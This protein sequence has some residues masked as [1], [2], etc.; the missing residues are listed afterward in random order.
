METVGA[1][2]YY[3]FDALG[4]VTNL[5]DENG[6]TSATYRYDVYGDF[7]LTGTSQGNPYTFIGRRYD[8]EIG[9]YYY[10]GRY[11]SPIIGRFLQTDSI[12]YS[13]GMNLYTYVL[14]SPTY[15]TDPFG[16]KVYPCRPEDI[17]ICVYQCIQMKQIFFSCTLH[18]FCIGEH[19]IC[20]RWCKCTDPSGPPTPNP[21]PK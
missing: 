4:S 13:D 16:L 11:Y 19:I 2:Y 7:Q 8:P 17:Q 10:R 14:N 15:Y 5:A 21:T 12:G 6:Q 9:L 18:C 3:H 1:R 20:S